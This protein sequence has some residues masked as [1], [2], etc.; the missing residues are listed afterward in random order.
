MAPQPHP[1]VRSLVAGLALIGLGA[2]HGYVAP[3]FGGSQWLGFLVQVETQYFY[4]LLA[5]SW[6]PG[7]TSRFRPSVG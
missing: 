6:R 5:H 4:A 7:P 3:I 2:G 1:F